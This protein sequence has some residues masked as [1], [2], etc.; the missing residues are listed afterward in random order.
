MM[1]NYLHALR[2]RNI[3]A[4]AGRTSAAWRSNNKPQKHPRIRG[5]NSVTRNAHFANVE[6][7]PHTRGKLNGSDSNP[8]LA[9]NIP[10]YAGKAAAFH[11]V[12]P[13]CGKHP[14]IRGESQTE[15]RG[16]GIYVETSPHT[17]GKPDHKFATTDVSRK[18][19]RIRGE[20][21]SLAALT[22]MQ[23]ETS[24]HT[25]GK[26]PKSDRL[27]KQHGNIPAY[28]GKAPKR[29]NQSSAKQKHPR[30]RGESTQ[31]SCVRTLA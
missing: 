14:R 16:D 3:P 7:S 19:P 29:P 27:R 1:S 9:R 24:P 23:L 11:V 17:R 15:A 21:I 13:M 22:I 4:Y 5:E 31:R 25:R 8:R 18:H 26:P 10:A 30:I 28:A 6:T 20:S 12:R 2:G